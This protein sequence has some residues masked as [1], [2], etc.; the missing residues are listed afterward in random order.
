MAIL[1]NNDAAIL[2][3]LHK[4]AYG[5]RPST[6]FWDRVDAM[7]DG[8]LETLFAE[9]GDCVADEIQRERAQALRD[10]RQ[11]ELDIQKMI[12]LGAGDRVDAIR[13]LVD[14]ADLDFAVNQDCEHFLWQRGIDMEFWPHYLSE[15]GFTRKGMI[16][17]KEAA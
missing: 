2:S 8:E 16:W 9:L 1:S 13:W 15:M 3:D 6:G 7:T 17:I 10:Q 12:D 5:C 11:L 4:D 14:G